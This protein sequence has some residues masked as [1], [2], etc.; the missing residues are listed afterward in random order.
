M[1]A[2]G[3]SSSG[4]SKSSDS[5]DNEDSDSEQ[6]RL[7]QETPLDTATKRPRPDSKARGKRSPKAKRPIRLPAKYRQ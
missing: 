4:S 5:E 2:K 6:D 3:S 1:C 7:T